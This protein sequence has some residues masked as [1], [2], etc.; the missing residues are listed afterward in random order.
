MRKW[1]RGVL[2]TFM[3]ECFIGSELP[4]EPGGPGGGTGSLTLHPYFC[5]HSRRTHVPAMLLE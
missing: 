1:G 3:S 2:G 4:G 5:M